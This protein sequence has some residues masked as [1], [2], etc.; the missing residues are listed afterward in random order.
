L[1]LRVLQIK[2][3]SVSGSSLNFTPCAIQGF[4]MYGVQGDIPGIQG[5]DAK[6]AVVQSLTMLVIATRVT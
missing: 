3:P 5:V 1:H 2:P 6:T 4:N